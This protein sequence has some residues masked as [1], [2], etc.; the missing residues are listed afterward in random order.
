ML[1]VLV[2]AEGRTSFLRGDASLTCDLARSSLD[3]S[4]TGIGNTT[5]DRDHTVTSV[6]FVDVPVSP[7][8]TFRTGYT[9][10]RIHSGFY[11]PG[12]META[13]VFERQGIIGS[14]GAKR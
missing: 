13:G 8:G 4:F 9:G 2:G 12:Q 1:G 11:G 5:T 3:A 10:N 6:R 14:F 7:R